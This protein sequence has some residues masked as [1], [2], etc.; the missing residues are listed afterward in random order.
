MRFHYAF[1]TAIDWKNDRPYICHDDLTEVSTGN[2]KPI[3]DA[4]CVRFNAVMHFGFNCPSDAWLHRKREREAVEG[5]QL[6]VSSPT[7]KCLV[8]ADHILLLID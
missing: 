2:R 3:P 4:I 8:G 1:Q 7:I 6:K 5:N